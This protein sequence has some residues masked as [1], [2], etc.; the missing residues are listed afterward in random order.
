MSSLL[1][2]SSKVCDICRFLWIRSELLFLIDFPIQIE[3]FW[4]LVDIKMKNVKLLF[5]QKTKFLPPPS[6]QSRSDNI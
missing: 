6:S 3:Y 1:A 5:F 4:R 2:E